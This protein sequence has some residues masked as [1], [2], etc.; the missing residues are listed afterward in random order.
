MVDFNA[1]VS[2]TASIFW[3]SAWAS[4]AGRMRASS[5]HASSSACRL[6]M[7]AW[8]ARPSFA[9]SMEA[10]KWPRAMRRKY[11]TVSSREAVAGRTA[12]SARAVTA[13]PADKDI[14]TGRNSRTRTMAVET[15]RMVRAN[16]LFDELHE[17]FHARSDG[18]GNWRGFGEITKNNSGHFGRRNRP[19]EMVALGFRA[20]EAA[21]VICLFGGFDPLGGDRQAQRATQTDDRPQD[22]AHVGFRIH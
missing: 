11:R 2:F 4:P 6:W 9:S 12:V 3:R 16:R 20:I 19:A 7:T 21:Q 15:L 22:V 18:A 10:S 13:Q 1:T 17:A 14:S 5:C 8:S